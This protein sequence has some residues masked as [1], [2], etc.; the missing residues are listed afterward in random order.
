MSAEFFEGT[1]RV[2]S[3]AFALLCRLLSYLLEETTVYDDTVVAVQFV[4]DIWFV[5]LVGQQ[6]VKVFM[7]WAYSWATLMLLMSTPLP[8]LTRSTF[9]EC[10]CNPGS[11]DHAR[12]ST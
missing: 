4:L 3:S 9:V 11:L 2:L 12:L 10:A 7:S 6:L 1:P 5:L 8:K